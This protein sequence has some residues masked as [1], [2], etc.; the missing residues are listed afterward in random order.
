MQ[1]NQ[2][3]IINIEADNQTLRINIDNLNLKI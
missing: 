1:E 3:K 2:N